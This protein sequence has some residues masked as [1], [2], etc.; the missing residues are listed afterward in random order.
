MK[1]RL[2]SMLLAAI[3]LIS[4]L[5]MVGCNAK[6]AQGVDSENHVINVGNTAA[7]SGDF[8]AVGVPFNYALEAYFWYFSEHT[9]GYS[10]ADG[11]KYTIALTHY[12]DGFDATR[13]VS[14]TERL[15]EDDMVFALVGH[16]GSNTVAATVDYIEQQGIPMVYGVCG[17]NQ[18]YD[19]ERNVMSIQPT[20]MTEGRS[21][22]ATAFATTENNLGLGGTK[23]GVIATTDEAGASIKEGIL[24]EQEV[25]GKVSNT[26][27][28]YQD[29]DAAAT[30]YNA[31]VNALKTAGCDVVIIA[32]NQA[33]FTNIANAFI[34]NNYD[35]VK[36]L[37][38]YVSANY[39]AMGGLLASGAI[40][41]TREIYAGAWL[42]TGSMP[43]DTKGWTD[44]VEYAKIMTLYAKHN[45]E[46]LITADDPT[47][48]AYLG[49]WFATEDWAAEGVSAYFLN[50]YAMAGYVAASAFCQGLERV[51][52]TDLSW[53]GYIDAMEEA[54][55]N[56]PMGTSV[57]FSNGKRI[58][59]DSLSVSKYTVAN[60]AV[61][62]VY[63]P[64]TDLT[65]IE[66]G[67]N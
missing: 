2:I 40:T 15:V 5:A 48:G 59:I 31:A 42:V 61:G 21:M 56:V 55:V 49:L 35:N 16:F 28:F 9:D 11:N 52:G 34:T 14:Y 58:A 26:D 10:D 22:L 36:I 13:G 27:I 60:F 19:S 3:M 37:T 62:E 18:L 46:T 50:S 39:A 57:D 66:N 38:S 63:R 33:P 47:Y 23:V 4:V 41:E 43:S 29:V 54:P 65:T 32:A 64:I 8:A 17:V 24:A 51:N 30:D 1:R 6:T 53:E 7:T 45:G 12:D 44:F 20:Y 67:V 25:L